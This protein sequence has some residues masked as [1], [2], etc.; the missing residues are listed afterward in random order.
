[1]GVVRAIRARQNLPR[2]IFKPFQKAT[3]GIV[4]H[5]FD[6]RSPLGT[7][8]TYMHYDLAKQLRDTG[9]AQAGQGSWVG[10]PDKII[11]HRNDRV[12]V[13]TLEELI[14]ACGDN[15]FVLNATD[16]RE[17]P[18]TWYAAITSPSV[19]DATG[20]TPHEA[21]AKVWLALNKVQ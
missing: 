19:T 20:A 13:P 15:F 18:N 2:I 10:P 11:W 1:V 21:V 3:D 17:N 16:V 7:R 12:Y 5:A 6:R 8:E 4:D 14:A 9:F